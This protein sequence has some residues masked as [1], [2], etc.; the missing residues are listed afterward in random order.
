MPADRIAELK[1]KLA[2]KEA[3]LKKDK[4]M[5]KLL[6]LK[7]E[8]IEKKLMLQKL[9]ASK[10]AA[11]GSRKSDEDEVAKTSAMVKVVLNMTQGLGHGTQAQKDATFKKVL[12]TVQ[13]REHEVSDALA[14]A[15]AEEKKGEASLDA[16]IKKQLPSTGKGDAVTKG[17][18]MLKQI[19]SQERRK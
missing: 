12:A 9:L 2:E 18:S 16:V 8:L 11:E 19:K 13:A 3:E 4:N 10:A 1:K 6:K 17:Q 15:D 5:M 14:R 7:K